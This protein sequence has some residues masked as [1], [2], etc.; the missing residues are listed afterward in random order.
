MANFFA[1]VDCGTS[2]IKAA[3]FTEKGCPKIIINKSYPPKVKNGCQIEQDPNQLLTKIYSSLKEAVVKSKVKPTS[4]CSL[5]ISTQ[6]ATLISIGKDKKP[7]TNFISWQDMRG[8]DYLKY[9]RNKISDKNYYKIT[10]LPNNPVFSLAKILW[11]KKKAPQI[12]KKTDKFLLL[13]SYILKEFGCRDYLED[14]SNASLTGLLNIKK[15]SWSKLILKAI[16]LKETKLAGLTSSGAVIGVLSKGAA[17]RSGLVEGIPLVSGG[18]DQQCAGL[19]AAAVKPGILGITFGTASVPLIYTPKPVF[20]PKMR[21][22]CCAHVLEGCWGLEGF[23]GCTGASIQ[24]LNKIT[25]GKIFDQSVFIKAKRSGP[26][27]GGVL[28]YPY[29]SGASCPNWNPKA[30]GV[31][32][33]LALSSTKFDLL[34]AVVEGISFETREILDLYSWLGI[35]IKEIRLTG[36]GA[37]N[38]FWNQ[39][40]ADIYQKKIL[41]FKNPDASL[42]GAA[43][44]AAYAAGLDKS[45][46][47]TAFRFSKPDKVFYPDKKQKMLYNKLHANYKHVYKV[48]DKNEIF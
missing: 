42:A 33:G 32:F 29:L 22:I 9:L 40:Q 46:K 38:K 39:I 45:L 26:G 41:T 14:Y 30:K 27:A 21:F 4:I 25:A 6:R 24:W 1:A 15:F 43:A 37:K 35:K 18:G 2:A 23:Q 47:K 13:H 34:R 28:F 36:G 8:K 10:G 7:L 3:I 11:V 5:S 31:F 44:L 12:Y 20:D 16:G 17:K 48:L 19:A